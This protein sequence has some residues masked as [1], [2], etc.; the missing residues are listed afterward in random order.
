MV[1]TA[2]IEEKSRLG[3]E[4]VSLRKKC[5]EEKQRLDGELEKMRKRREAMEQEEH[6]ELLRQIDAEFDNE[7]GKLLGQRKAIAEVNRVS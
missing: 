1:V 5:K 4:K 7:H 2:L 6:A 3:E